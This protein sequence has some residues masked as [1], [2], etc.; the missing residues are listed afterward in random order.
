MRCSDSQ[1]LG[2]LAALLR[3]SNIEV[4]TEFLAGVTTGTSDE[5][6]GEGGGEGGGRGGEEKTG[7]KEGSYMYIYR[8]NTSHARS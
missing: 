2:V 7:K 1:V 3:G 8:G 5:R 4:A 6:E